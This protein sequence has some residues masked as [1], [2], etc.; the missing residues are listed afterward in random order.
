MNARDN[1]IAVIEKVKGAVRD[2]DRFEAE[3]ERKLGRA[4]AEQRKELMR[5]LGDPPN[6]A[7]VP[8]SYWNNGGK[9]IRRA[10]ASVFE[11]I[12]L[13]QEM[14][15]SE[16]ARIGIDWTLANKQAAD[17]AYR[18][19]GELSNTLN[20]TTRNAVA[21]YVGKFFDRGWT[22]D[23]LASRINDVVFSQA[24]SRAIAITETTR[25]ATQAELA[26]VN[27]YEATY[28]VKYKPFWETVLD[29]QVCDIC[30][31]KHG[32]EITD[33]EYPPAHVHCRCEV[34]WVIQ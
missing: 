7:N 24:R 10:V 8:E 30:G 25:A 27:Y 28:G 6:M 2:R 26:T 3:M 31:P 16:A 12:Y 18:F 29:D 21:D 17:W 23:E 1:L 34:N 11:E 32:K 14:A 4:W 9:A 15:F 22:M 20:D 13:S 19:A 5:L 33:G